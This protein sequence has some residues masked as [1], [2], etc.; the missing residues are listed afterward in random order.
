MENT[1]RPEDK[2]TLL[3]LRKS[4]RRFT[5]EKKLSIQEQHIQLNKGNKH[6]THTPSSTDLVKLTIS[7]V[8]PLKHPATTVSFGSFVDEVI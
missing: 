1:G 3:V 6:K 8:I 2:V 7:A 4:I 5:T